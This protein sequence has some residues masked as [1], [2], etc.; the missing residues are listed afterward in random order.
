MAELQR[1][2]GGGR[3]L[4]GAACF[5]VVVAGMKAAGSLIVPFLLAIFIAVIC[6]PPMSW[7]RKKGIPAGLAIFLIVAAVIGLFTLLGTFVG[8]NVNSFVRDLPKYEQRLT[9]QSAD[10]VLWLEGHGVDVSQ[11]QFRSHFNASAVMKV[12]ANTLTGMSGVLKNS[13]MIMITVVFILLEAAGFPGKLRAAVSNPDQ[14]MAQADS[15]KDTVNRYLGMKSLFSLLTGILIWIWLTILGVDYALLWG[16]LAML[17]NFV[18]TIGSILAAIPAVLLA[19][20]QL[21]PGPAALTAGGF[22]AVNLAIGS[23][24]EPRFMGKGLGLSTLV[25]FVSLVFW[26]WV[27]GPVGMLLSVPLT[28]ILKIMLE[29]NEETRGI[30]I[31]L[32][33]GVKTPAPGK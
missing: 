30:A 25:V 19:L 15:M 14:S 1:P 18:P 7:M 28:M 17:L 12:I 26:G 22:L 29:S 4:L 10:L 32:G 11:E 3:F 13:L 33:P 27:L 24:I 5:V 2:S 31:M 6:L 16:V 23:A 21:G 8:A 20:V 9:E